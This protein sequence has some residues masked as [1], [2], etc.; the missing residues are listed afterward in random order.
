MKKNGPTPDILKIDLPPGEALRRLVHA[1]PITRKASRY[2]K[3][4]P[5]RSA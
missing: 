3:R 2:T 4:K 1:K 5:K